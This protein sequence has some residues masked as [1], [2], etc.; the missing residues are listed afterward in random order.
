MSTEVATS[1]GEVE[2]LQS[3]I[4]EQSS[5]I[6]QLST[7]LQKLE[8]HLQQ[9]LRSKY[10]PR[11]ERFDPDQGTLF[12]EP[13]QQPS[14]QEEASSTT[15]KAHR[16]RGGGRGEL[17]DHLQR[18]I[19]EH[20]LSA[21][22]K[23]CPGCGVERK[24]IGAEVSEQLEH[25]PAVLYVLQHVRHKYA[26]RD[27]Q[28]HVQVAPPAAKPIAK[29]L[30]GVGLLSALVVSK[31]HDHLPPTAVPLGRYLFSQRC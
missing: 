23:L 27:C 12:D 30:P 19:I 6:Q 18:H 1:P 2:Q 16:R 31:Y 26:C 20:D 5:T 21:E 4:S 25:E 8:H 28:E 3:I 24:R 11:A 10:G 22:E 13:V 15:V 17:P 14:E 7:K 29:G 9:L